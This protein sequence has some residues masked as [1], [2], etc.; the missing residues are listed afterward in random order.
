MWDRIV[1]EAPDF[2]TY[3]NAIFVLQ[4]MGRTL[5]LTVIGCVAGF[6][7]GFAIAAIRSTRARALLPLRLLVTVYVEIF[8]RIPFLVILFIVMFGIQAVSR[9]I[10]LFAIALIS[11]CMVSTA[12]MSEIIRAGMESVPKMQREAAEAMNFGFM[13][14]LL[15]VILPQAWKVILPPGFAFMVMFIKDTALVSQ[16]GVVELAFTGKMFVG[17]GFSPF[18]V[19][20]TVLAGYFVMS[21]P[22]SRLGAY[23]ENRLA[24]SRSRESIQ[25]VWTGP[26]PVQS[27]PVGEQG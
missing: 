25:R 7:F 17:R 4:A 8:R 3:Y 22:L 18:L 2:F 10:S 16:M 27:E 19:Y 6:I 23:L 14:T 9:G 12:F 13:R 11:I 21:Y 1:Q 20:G 24:T 15:L 5:A 26:G